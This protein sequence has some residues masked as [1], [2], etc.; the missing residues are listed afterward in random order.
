MSK[1]KSFTVTLYPA[2]ITGAFITTKFS[3]G[4]NL[5]KQHI[6]ASSIPEMLAQVA[7]IAT[8]SGTGTHAR[9]K[10]NEKRKPN[11]FDAATKKLYFN[12]DRETV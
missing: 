1:S 3:F 7:T 6:Q 8:E 9:V 12:L 2:E 5:H 11:G 4:D 10:C